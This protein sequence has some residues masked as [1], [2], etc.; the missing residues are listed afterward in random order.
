MFAHRKMQP[1]SYTS[2][3]NSQR[4]AKEEVR[5][6]DRGGGGQLDQPRCC[7]SNFALC[8]RSC[9]DVLRVEF[10]RPQGELG[11][12]N[13]GLKMRHGAYSRG[14]GFGHHQLGVGVGGSGGGRST[15]ALTHG[16]PRKRGSLNGGLA[17]LPLHGNTL[18]QQQMAMQAAAANASPSSSAAAAM[19]PVPSAS[20][21]VAAGGGGVASAASSASSPLHS[22]NAA[23]AANG[24]AAG[25][26][27]VGS[28]SSSGSGG[29]GGGVSSSGASNQGSLMSRGHLEMFCCSNSYVLVS[30]FVSPEYDKPGPEIARRITEDFCHQFRTELEKYRIGAPER[31]AS[32][33]G[34]SEEALLDEA[35]LPVFA[36]FRQT[37]ESSGVLRVEPKTSSSSSSA[38]A[39]NSAGSS[40]LTQAHPLLSI[41]SSSTLGAEG[42]SNAPSPRAAGAGGAKPGKS[43][44]T[45][46]ANHSPLIPA[47]DR[48]SHQQQQTQHHHQSQTPHL[49][50]SLP[51]AFSTQSRHLLSVSSS[52]GATTSVVIGSLPATST[53]SSDPSLGGGGGAYG[54][55]FGLLG[56]GSDDY[57]PSWI[58]DSSHDASLALLQQNLPA[59]LIAEPDALL[60]AASTPPLP[61][62]NAAIS[63]EMQSSRSRQVSTSTAPLIHADTAAEVRGSSSPPGAPSASPPLPQG[64]RAAAGLDDIHVAIE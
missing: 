52:H 7:C 29:V 22:P 36:A 63:I 35:L 3:H 50:S 24:S 16:N 17:S 45:S 4:I 20:P 60:A 34:G 48:R 39:A 26:N 37:L 15:L 8:S 6:T 21:S 5:G 59:L 19:M 13:A 10:D 1:H 27:G 47:V 61:A 30:I 51:A 14:V 44:R 2:S 31:T 18:L 32:Y 49:S 9:A 64:G 43:F 23:S 56:A 54:A 12:G 33:P 46:A 41:G 57:L 42:G 11:F 25:S 58:A 53:T 40:P 28:S 55:N 62:S 38:S